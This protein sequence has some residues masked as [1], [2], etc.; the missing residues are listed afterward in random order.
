MFQ[1]LTLKEGGN[2]GFRGNKKG[3]IIDMG[4]IGNSSIPI[5][6]GR[7]IDRLKHNLLSIIQFCDSGYE[8]VFNKNIYIVVNDSENFIVLI[9]KRKGSVYKINFLSWLIRICFSFYQRVMKNGSGTEG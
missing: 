6:N 5:N 1:T 9:G 8:V 7:F 4:T 2:V 3:N